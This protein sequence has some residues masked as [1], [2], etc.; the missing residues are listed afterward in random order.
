M[1][2]CGPVPGVLE[3][4][5][6][7][8]VVS[9]FETRRLEFGDKL[10]QRRERAGLTGMALSE[11]LGWTG[12]KVSKI[13]TG[14]Q[15]ATDSDVIDWCAAVGVPD[16]DREAL[17]AELRSLRVQQLGW[18]R[19]LR[20]GHEARQRESAATW[21]TA[22]RIRGAAT[23]AVPGML[24]TAAYMRALFERQTELLRVPRDIDAAVAARLERQQLLYLPGRDVEILV[25]E[26]A[27]ANPPCS[28]R[29]M[30]AQIDRLVSAVDLPTVRFGVVPLYRPLPVLLPD[31]FW[32]FDDT[33][34]IEAVTTD[35]RITDPDQVAVY[36]RLADQLWSVAVTGEEA[37]ALLI[38]VG[39]RWAQAA[40]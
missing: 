19:Q 21:Q 28:P 27:L 10:R 4:L 20:A 39:H 25:A 11:R 15:T 5:I 2:S 3:T 30:V 22:T 14:K 8:S 9:E 34:R 13:E 40:K 23:K 18:R 1:G 32:I 26:A 35:D 12:S 29:D 33:V 24:Q 17:R 36:E 16:T 37:R 6:E 31:S 7:E 38:A